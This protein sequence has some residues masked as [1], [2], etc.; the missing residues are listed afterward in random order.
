[1]ASTK[2]SVES[3]YSVFSE[4]DPNIARIH[5]NVIDAKA[6]WS[7]QSW[8]KKSFGLNSI[9]IG[10]VYVAFLCFR[11]FS[12]SRFEKYSVV[13]I[14]LQSKSFVVLRYRGRRSNKGDIS[15]YS[16]DF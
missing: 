1:M 3:V 7:F 8:A 5:P 12:C 11:K 15:C 6:K 4:G 10:L 9:D 16:Q 14:D 13:V 2:A